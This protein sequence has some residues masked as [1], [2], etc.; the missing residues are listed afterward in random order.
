MK[1]VANI[2]RCWYDVYKLIITEINTIKLL[3]SE[4]VDMKSDNLYR[5]F[6]VFKYPVPTIMARVLLANKAEQL[7][8]IRT[9]AKLDHIWF[10]D[11]RNKESLDDTD[12]EQDYIKDCVYQPNFYLFLVKA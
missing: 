4:H 9:E 1:F 12:H 6:R 11:H 3:D 10:E 2:K 7:Q 5:V 8:M